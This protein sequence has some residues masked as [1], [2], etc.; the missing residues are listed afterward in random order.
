MIGFTFAQTHWAFYPITQMIFLEIFMT[1][2]VIGK[3]I[4]AHWQCL[5]FI[6]NA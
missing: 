4:L 5:D 3:K 1:Q 6:T 2:F